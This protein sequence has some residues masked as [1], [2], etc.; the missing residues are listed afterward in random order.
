VAGKAICSTRRAKSTKKDILKNQQLSQTTMKTENTDI[1]TDTSAL[2]QIERAQ[3]DMQIATARRYPRQLSLV[4]SEMMSFATLD[5]DTASG[6]FYTLPGRKGGDGKPLQGP[7]VRLAEIALSC[8]QHL[9]AGS[10]IVDDDGKFITAQG[11]VHDLQNNVVIS[12][13]VKRRVTNKLGQRY[14]DDMIAT[15]GNAA[16]SIALRNATFRVIP[17]ALVKPVYEAAKMLAI[18]DVKSLVQR[19]SEA[20][21]R[22]LKLGVKTEQIFSVLSVRSLE[23]IKLDHLEILFGYYTAIKDGDATIDEI[24]EPQQDMKGPAKQPQNPYTADL[25]APGTF[26]DLKGSIPDEMDSHPKPDQSVSASDQLSLVSEIKAALKSTELT[27]ATFAP[28]A[29]EAG[30]LAEGVQL[31]G[32]TVEELREILANLEDIISGNYIPLN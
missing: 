10:R 4:K 17:M 19:R 31:A 21:A 3:I 25:K 15:T 7:S 2:L 13:E 23:D 24:F 30:L 12:I 14:S 6:C 1:V 8:Y 9:R 27:V 20:I 26:A 5:E 16:C 18:G 29:R 32:A 11:V 22:F 28:K